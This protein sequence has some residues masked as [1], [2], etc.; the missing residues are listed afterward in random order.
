MVSVWNGL[1]RR[2][3]ATA[4]IN[5]EGLDCFHSRR[6]GFVQQPRDIFG[7]KEIPPERPNWV[8]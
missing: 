6:F 3:T 5:G 4:A 7:P 1:G 2:R 8:E